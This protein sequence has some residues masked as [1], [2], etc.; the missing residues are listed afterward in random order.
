MSGSTFAFLGFFAVLV[1][2]VALSVLRSTADRR[3]AEVK[4]SVTAYAE[5]ERARGVTGPPA[6]TWDVGR[7]EPVQLPSEAEVVQ[8]GEGEFV[9]EAT[10]VPAGAMPRASVPLWALVSAYPPWLFHG[11][12]ALASLGLGALALW[13]RA[14]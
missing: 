3:W 7:N 11:A 5:A 14:Q 6:W 8:Q 4:A 1:A 9:V 12:F 13:L 10:V 2:W